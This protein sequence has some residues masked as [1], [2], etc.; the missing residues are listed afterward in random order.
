M[1]IKQPKLKKKQE[2]E[3]ESYLEQLKRLQAEFENYIKRVEKDQ[4]RTIQNAKSQL[5][6]KFIAIKENFERAIPD[7]KQN[8]G[9][10]MI[11]QQMDKLL[12]EEGIREIKTI[13]Q[14]FDHALHEVIKTIDGAENKVLEVVQQGY[15]FG[16]KILRP[17]K[18]IIGK[19]DQ[20]DP[21]KKSVIKEKNTNGG[22]SK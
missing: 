9:L 14:T 3:D 7:N 16:D 6:L 1:K 19:S 15:H 11:H 22:H 2:K 4:Q 8:R 13:G 18:V 20:Q 21:S 5:F 10:T 17:S 12:D